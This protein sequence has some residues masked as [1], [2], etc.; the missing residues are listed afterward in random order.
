MLM[1]FNTIK[2][3]FNTMVSHK[4]QK[5]DRLVSSKKWREDRL[6]LSHVVIKKFMK[7]SR[8][9][10]ERKTKKKSYRYS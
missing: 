10:Y 4:K 2:Q 8:R 3:I 5:Y 7:K 9:N 6:L 1:V